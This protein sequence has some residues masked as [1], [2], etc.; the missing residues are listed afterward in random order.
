MDGRLNY[1]MGTGVVA[2]STMRNGEL[3]F[4]VLQ[5]HQVHGDRIEI[6]RRRDMTREDLE[7]V[8]GLITDLYGLAI[9]VRT[10]DCVPVLL[11]ENEANVVA[12][13]HSGWRGTVARISQKCIRIM[14][15]EFGAD[16]GKMRAVIGPSIG[17]ESF[18]V[19]EEVVEEFRKAGLPMD[20]IASYQGERTGS[21]MDGGWHIDLWKANR[22]LLE[23]T[24]IRSE[25]IEVCGVCTYE[26]NDLFFSA[27]HEGRKC[28][29]I[30][31]VIKMEDER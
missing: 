1:D 9:G 14:A 22:W 28:G 26:R 5:P 23:E 4:P 13:V 8:D 10:A 7:G 12:A 15:E 20:L 27:R 17:P 30:I 24:G 19:G 21:G 16:S 18:Q 6:V 3:P 11:Y 31:N 29:R 2:F 25:N